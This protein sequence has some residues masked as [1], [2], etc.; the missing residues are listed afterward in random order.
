[1]QNIKLN[2]VVL[3][4]GYVFESLELS[5][6]LFGRPL[7]AAPIVLINH[8]LT[9]NS[10]V[11]GEKGWWRELVGDGRCIDTQDYT[12]LS[13]NIPGNGYDG[14]I[15]DNYKDFVC[16]DIAKLFLNA[17]DK[18]GVKRLFALIGGSLGGGIAWEMAAINPSICEYLI[19]IATDWKSTDWLIANCQIQEQILLNSSKP[20]NDARMHAMLCYRTPESFSQRFQRKRDENQAIYQVES[21]LN[22]HGDQLEKR[23]ELAA[24]KLM[25]QLLKTINVKDS[26]SDFTQ[27]IDKIDAE[28]HIVGVGSDLFFSAKE[29]RKTYA[30]ISKVKN[31]VFYH[32]IES[33]HGHDAFLIESKQLSSMLN[34]IFNKRIVGATTRVLKF[35]GKSL[36]NGKGFYRVLDILLAK[37][38]NQERIAVVLSARGNTTDWLLDLL[39]NAKQGNFDQEGID[40][41]IA[42]QKEVASEVDLSLF[43]NSIS[44]I[45]KGVSVLGDCS[46]KIQD[47]LL[48]QGELMSCAVLSAAL[49]SKGY[50]GEFIDTREFLVSN[51]DFGKALVD[52]YQSE[53]NFRTKVNLVQKGLLIFPGFIAA[54]KNGETTTLGRNGSNYS[55]ALI[56]HLLGAVELESYTHVSGIYTANPDWVP[57][58]EKI[59]NL[60][61]SEANEMAN[62]GA[63]ILHAKSV[64]PLL[65][66]RIPL[67]ILN[68]FDTK[69][70]GTLIGDGEVEK[71]IKA[72]SVQQ[73]MALVNIEG[74]GLLGKVGVD[75]RIFG[76]LGH[77]GISVGIISQGASERGIGFVVAEKDAFLAKQVLEKEFLQDFIRKDMTEISVTRD[78]AVVSV[79]GQDLLGFHKAL[80]ALD[81]NQIEP[82]LI[83]NTLS[84]QNIC[85]V[86]TQKDF[87]KALNVIHGQI[88]GMYKTINLAIFGKG[89][90][91]GTLIDQILESQKH[92]LD[93]R[94]VKL[95]IF[96]VA[97]SKQLL[98]SSQGITSNW[99]EDLD[100][101]PTQN[102]RVERVKRFTKENHLENLIAID[103][104]ASAEFVRLYPDLIE[105]GFD[106]VS[107]N[108]VANTIDYEYYKDLRACLKANKKQYLYETNVGAGLPL[109]DT[110]KMLHDSGEQITKIKGVFSGSLSYIFN[111]FSANSII[112]FDSVLREAIEKGY[113]EPD[114]RE[115]LCGNDVGRKL[116]ILARELDLKNEFEDIQIENLIPE[117][118]RSLSKAEFLNSLDRFNALYENRKQCQNKDYVLRYVG[119]LSGD[120][121]QEKGDLNVRLVSVP[122]ESSLGQISG[123]DSL[124]EIYTRSYG[125][126]PIVIQGAGAGAAVTARGV[127]G[128]VLRLTERAL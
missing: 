90:V 7:G 60:S 77:A 16:R 116:L 68:T 87:H 109:I 53:L 102:N 9:G 93:R 71:R 55:A 106:L 119:E 28:I 5:Y 63:N 98:L 59:K 125:D 82:L 35:G 75:A 97:N 114:P 43:Q 113:T 100:K 108:K 120:L 17:L 45:L 12:V 111:T 74:R 2:N 83:N 54:D 37:L 96:A 15:L 107:S 89:L 52:E 103:N 86:I 36:A 24:Y 27:L 79:I 34:P 47:L 48:A 21:W 115:D 42:Y 85:L 112:S 41:L 30:Q 40:A 18:L 4:S 56:A 6:E 65:T 92:I 64:I 20:V 61:Y 124:F 117:D 80:A 72:L 70:T 128:D 67:R 19:P 66:N 22:Y 58:A 3:T 57:S 95:N 62:F 39:N 51:S 31:H 46:L 127:L 26:E 73:H 23:F 11:A 25:N 14:L 101:L 118:L 123:S 88:F 32:E 13:F 105:A 76:A 121:N 1:M 33:P 44:Q 8:A 29:N 78:L 69:D 122:K 126:Q 10:N 50:S 94:K 49:K 38:N 110:I 99:R 91:G 104:T 84:G 81:R